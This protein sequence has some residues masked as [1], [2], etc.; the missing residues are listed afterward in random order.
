MP[1][2]KEQLLKRIEEQRGI[3]GD[4]MTPR[5]WRIELRHRRLVLDILEY[6]LLCDTARKLD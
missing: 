4:T 2:T 3:E 5:N 1:D 6:L